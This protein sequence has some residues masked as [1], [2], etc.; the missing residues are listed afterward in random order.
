MAKSKWKG[1][2]FNEN[3]LKNFLQFKSFEKKN[4]RKKIISNNNSIIP[5]FLINKNVYT[6]NGRKLQ[7]I[8]IQ[9]SKVGYYLNTFLI[10]KKFKKR[11][12]SKKTNL[13]KKKHG[14]KI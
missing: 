11:N 5:T 2:T 6:Y 12:F 14:S 13:K 10:T 9:N 4:F 7:K 3:L 1:V 8:F